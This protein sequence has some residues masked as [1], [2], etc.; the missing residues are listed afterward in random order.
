M[1]V[2]AMRTG[3]TGRDAWKQFEA[4]AA[5]GKVPAYIVEDFEA[6]AHI[7][8]TYFGECI[9]AAQQKQ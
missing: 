2:V 4:S 9:D 5:S 3:L 6:M 1:C 7:A 8:I